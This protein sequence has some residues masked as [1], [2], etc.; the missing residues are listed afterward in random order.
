MPFDRLRAHQG[1]VLVVAELVE[2]IVVDSE[3]MGDLVY[4]SDPDLFDDL[5]AGFTNCQDRSPEDQ[6]AI[7]QTGVELTAFGQWDA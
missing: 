1:L 3:V 7:G 6:D 2:P 5:L 4:D